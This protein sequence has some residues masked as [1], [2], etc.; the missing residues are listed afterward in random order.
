VN[1]STTGTLSRF[2]ALP[3]RLGSPCVRKMQ[4]SMVYKQIARS[5]RSGIVVREADEEELRKLRA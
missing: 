4:R 1:M 3:K 2:L 5:P